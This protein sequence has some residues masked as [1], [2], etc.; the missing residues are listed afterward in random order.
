MKKE[1]L[2]Q[3][4]RRLLAAYGP[5][6]W[7]PLYERGKMRY[8]PGNYSMPE[9][10]SQRFEICAGAILTQNTSWKGAARAIANL[11][12]L[13]AL[14]PQKILSLSPSAL[15]AAIK[16][17]GYFNQKA[18]KLKVFCRFYAKLKGRVP[19]RAEL[20]SLWGIGPE[21]AD[22]ILLYAY[23]KP[24]F[25]VDAYTRR[26]LKAEG[27]R[28]HNESYEKIKGFFEENLPRD[29]RLFNEFHALIVEWGKR[30]KATD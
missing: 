6:G 22:S 24:E 11:R 21:T 12:R 15:K 27:S 19:E 4:Y 20:L 5:Q 17:A 18:R 13:R 14:S 16:P 3:V 30:T 23:K 9:N 1:R 2:R 8:R 7:W 28:L 10:E 25:V 29:F 26:L